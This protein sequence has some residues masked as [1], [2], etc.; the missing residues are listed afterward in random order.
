MKKGFT[1]IELLV[2]LTIIAILAAISIFGTQGIREQGRDA[3]RKSDL[4]TIRSGLETYKS[5]CNVYPAS[6]TFGGS[7]NGGGP[8]PPSCAVANQYM[9]K[10]PTDP[11][12]PSSTYAYTRGMSQTTYVL[13]AKLEQAPNP[14]MD[15]SGCGSCNGTCNYKVVSP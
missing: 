7:L 8:P 5:D 6:L 2:A 9:A 12:D 4:E 15:V 14:A 10:I 3:K 13:C 1:L 11:Q